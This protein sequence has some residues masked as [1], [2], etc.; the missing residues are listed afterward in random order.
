MKYDYSKITDR[1][2][3]WYRENARVLP[4]RSEPKP[5]YVWVSEIMLQ[6]T[7]VEAVKEYF[8]RFIKELPD[9]EALSMVKEEKL[10]KLWE[11]LGYYNRA[12]NLKKAAAVV[13]EEYNG[14]LPSEY[15]ELLKLPG[16]GS[17]TAGAISSI[18]YQRAVP[19]VD[20]NVLRV[21]KRLSAGYEDITKEAVKKEIFAELQKAM[22]VSEPGNFNQA[23]MELGALVCIPNGKPLCFSCPLQELCLACQQE[24]VMELPVKPA[25]KGRKIE[26]K[27][28]L[29][30]EYQGK[31]ALHKR[32]EKGL[33]AGLWEFPGLAGKF[34]IE[35]IEHLLEENKITEYRM[36]L[37]GEAKHIF[38]HVEW[39]MLGYGIG[40]EKEN[41]AFEG[42]ELYS[43][44]VWVEKERLEREYALPSAFKA[45]KDKL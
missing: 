37:L 2:L 44:L 1:L 14:E 22:P 7:R 34:S 24:V 20:G 11:G 32:S 40:I 10:L 6:Q 8:K 42:C 28:V 38:S 9:I 39:H 29:V 25:K 43:E 45:Y 18:A 3:L 15:G 4:W 35:R 13:M 12:R 41:K 17:Y 5:Y 27:T 36:E 33:L 16:I 26:E 30:L 21:T 31:Y 19:A 23:L